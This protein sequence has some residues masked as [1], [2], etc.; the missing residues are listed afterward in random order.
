[1]EMS[2]SM[3]KQSDTPVSAGSSSAGSVASAASAVSSGAFR[4]HPYCYSDY[5]DWT[6]GC[7]T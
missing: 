1:M 5:S 2:A 6:A 3:S 4:L 7:H